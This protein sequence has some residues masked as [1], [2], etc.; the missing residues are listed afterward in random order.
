MIRKGTRI[1]I[2]DGSEWHNKICLVEDID[3]DG[4]PILFCQNMQGGRRYWLYD[5]LMNKVNLFL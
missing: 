3:R 2:Q 5:N 1:I 4:V